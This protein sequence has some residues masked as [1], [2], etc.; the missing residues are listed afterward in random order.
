MLLGS[1]FTNYSLVNVK[2]KNAGK[3]AFEKIKDTIDDVVKRDYEKIEISHKDLVKDDYSKG[4]E[5]NFCNEK[6]INSLLK[7]KNQSTDEWKKSEQYS[8]GDIIICGKVNSGRSFDFTLGQLLSI[9][10]TATDFGSNMKM[11]E[12]VINLVLILLQVFPEYAESPSNNAL[13]L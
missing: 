13:P 5:I 6:I 10:N 12:I 11:P 2:T 7:C 1:R 4:I 8:D 9:W 3:K